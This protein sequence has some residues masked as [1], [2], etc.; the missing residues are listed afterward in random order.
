MYLWPLVTA[1]SLFGQKKPIKLRLCAG[2][3]QQAG[4]FTVHEPVSGQCAGPT[5]Q[6]RPR[7]TCRTCCKQVRQCSVPN[8]QAPHLADW[9]VFCAQRTSTGKAKVG[10]QFTAV[11]SVEVGAYTVHGHDRGRCAEPTQ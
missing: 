2:S 5:Q 11:G 4:A 9:L 6:A 1:A 8:G 3:E 10:C 7:G